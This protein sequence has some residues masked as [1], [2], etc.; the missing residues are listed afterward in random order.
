MN[1]NNSYVVSSCDTSD[2]SSSTS[3]S[4]LDEL[5]LEPE[6]EDLAEDE[7]EEEELDDFDAAD[8]RSDLW[9]QFIFIWIKVKKTTYCCERIIAHDIIIRW[10]AW[11]V[12]E[13]I[14]TGKELWNGIEGVDNNLYVC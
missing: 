5:E 6:L 14:F 8:T 4:E 1:E 9:K 12:G 3:S 11:N 10:R 7:D 2:F 13:S